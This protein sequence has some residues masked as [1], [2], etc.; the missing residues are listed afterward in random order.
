MLSH[1]QPELH[2]KI[3]D[4]NQKYGLGTKNVILRGYPSV[5]FCSTRADPDEQEKTRLIR[6]SPSTDQVKLRESLELATLRRSNPDE[7][8]R[9]IQLDP[10]RA[11][12]ANRIL[13]IRQWGIKEVNIP[14]DGK[15]VYARFMKEHPYLRPRHQRDFPRIFSFIKAHGLLNCFNRTRLEGEGKPTPF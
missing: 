2:Y 10:E 11:W 14:D 3:T 4:K 8:R 6:L 15:S 7:Y 12:L 1:D 13:G 9:R 5:F